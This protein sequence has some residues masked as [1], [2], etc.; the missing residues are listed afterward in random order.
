[1]PDDEGP[2]KPFAPYQID[3]GEKLGL[4]Q[5][6]AATVISDAEAAAS[7][8]PIVCARV[9]P[10]A[11]LSRYVPGSVLRNCALCTSSVL[12]SPASQIILAQGSNPLLCM[13]CYTRLL[14][15]ES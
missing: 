13:E 15:A 10:D 8:D 11:D 4:D 2:E 5:P 7:Q 12:I 6:F 9:A 14:E 3:L 1:M